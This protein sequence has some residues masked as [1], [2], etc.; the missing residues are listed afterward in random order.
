MET[1]TLTL[2][3]SLKKDLL[4]LLEANNFNLRSPEVL[5]LSHKIDVLML[6]LFKHQLQ[7]H[8]PI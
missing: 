7:N 5:E 2:I 8:F 6:P 3:M 1:T 4:N